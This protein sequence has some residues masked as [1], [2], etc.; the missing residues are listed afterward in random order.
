MELH[1]IIMVMVL[2]TAAVQGYWF[3]A[4][5]RFDAKFVKNVIKCVAYMQQY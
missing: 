1:V 5:I 2:A 3:I 4:E